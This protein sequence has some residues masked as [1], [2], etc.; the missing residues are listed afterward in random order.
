[1][2]PRLDG[3]IS[4]HFFNAPFA[5]SMARRI[6]LTV[7]LGTVSTTSPVAGLRTSVVC[8][9][10]E[11]TDSPATNIL[12]IMVLLIYFQN[13]EKNHVHRWKST[14]RGAEKVDSSPLCG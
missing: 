5:A 6:S 3:A 13:L 12:A 7:P 11:S 10:S 8:P 2:L 9:L 1:M 14:I 4:D